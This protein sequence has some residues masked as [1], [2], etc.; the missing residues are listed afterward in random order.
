M[1]V[2]C[3]TLILFKTH[4]DALIGFVRSRRVRM[5]ASRSPQRERADPLLCP[6]LQSPESIHG[7]ENFSNIGHIFFS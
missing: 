2:N 5:A 6:T 4:P 1:S 3:Y 7:T